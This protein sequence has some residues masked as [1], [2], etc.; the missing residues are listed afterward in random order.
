M[1]KIIFERIRRVGLPKGKYAVFG[2]ALLDVWGIR[3]AKDIDIIV[4][5]DLFE[6]LKESGDWEVI[7][8]NGF[9]LLRRGDADVTTA[10]DAPTDGTY[11]PDRL[12]LI[13][14][15]VIIMGIPFVR[16]EHV[17]ECKK[18]YGRP[19][20]FVDIASIEQYIATHQT[21]LYDL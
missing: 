6:S 20:D 5:P 1:K 12:R 16:I 14:E 18:A 2:S 13:E 15:A 10:Q 9:P 4:T 17:I 8:A 19:K 7:Q 3:T 11:C 21:N